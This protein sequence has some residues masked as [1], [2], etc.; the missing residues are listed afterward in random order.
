MAR[1]AGGFSGALLVLLGVCWVVEG[2]IFS[3]GRTDEGGR[4]SGTNE[5]KSPETVPAR[6]TWRSVGVAVR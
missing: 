3:K 4:N 5:V 6:V 1:I 2:N